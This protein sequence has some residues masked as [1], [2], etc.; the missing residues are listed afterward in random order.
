MLLLHFFDLLVW[1]VNGKLV[2]KER[3]EEG[4]GVEEVGGIWN[5]REL[6]RLNV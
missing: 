6:I 5:R 1:G 3:G 4:R 2:E